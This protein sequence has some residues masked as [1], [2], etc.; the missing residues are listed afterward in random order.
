MGIL[1]APY[2]CL[3]LLL[4]EFVPPKSTE[5]PVQDF[6]YFC[7]CGFFE[8]VPGDSSMHSEL[9]TTALVYMPTYPP[10]H[11]YSFLSKSPN[12]PLLCT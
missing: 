12:L 1:L 9:E 3:Y 5:V 4:K 2:P 10:S 11:S 8:K 7:V 6:A